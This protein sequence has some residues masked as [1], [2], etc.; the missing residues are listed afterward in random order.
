MDETQQNVQNKLQFYIYEV[1]TYP[2]VVFKLGP[3]LRAATGEGGLCLR[4]LGAG[5]LM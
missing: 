1:D 3:D 4:G 2:A 5:P